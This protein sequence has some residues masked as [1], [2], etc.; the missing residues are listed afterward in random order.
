MSYYDDGY[1]VDP[2]TING[3]H[4]P[5][6]S[7]FKGQ[8][9]QQIFCSGGGMS[10]LILIGAGVIGYFL[11]SGSM[12]WISLL[13]GVG[14]AGLNIAWCGSKLGYQAVAGYDKMSGHFLY[15]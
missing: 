10:P 13:G 1:A 9:I 15:A 8:N 5:D 14:L 11:S 3:P 2:R 7:V 12:K 4:L 6:F